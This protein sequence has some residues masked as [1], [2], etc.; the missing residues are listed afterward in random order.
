MPTLPTHGWGK[1]STWLAA[2]GSWRIC[3]RGPHPLCA[4]VAGVLK[5]ETGRQGENR[6][7]GRVAPVCRFQGWVGTVSLKR[8]FRRR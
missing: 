4:D 1:Q 8:G 5:H 2:S 7:R 3:G 6:C